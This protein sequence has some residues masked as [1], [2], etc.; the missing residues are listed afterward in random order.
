[1]AFAQHSRSFTGY[2]VEALMLPGADNIR[3]AVRLLTTDDAPI[4]LRL[5][6]ASLRFWHAAVAYR[7]WPGDLQQESL[8][9]ESYLIGNG[10][11]SSTL[12]EM[13]DDTAFYLGNQILSFAR[14]FESVSD[15]S[16]GETTSRS[17]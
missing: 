10:R 5:H 17:D 14:A 4:K 1:M 9:I 15:N 8:R 12:G 16:S 6:A 3:E 7:T 11:E 2:S 13:N